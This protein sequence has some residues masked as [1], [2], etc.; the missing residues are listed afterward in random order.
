MNSYIAQGVTSMRQEAVKLTA[1]GQYK[2]IVWEQVDDVVIEVYADE[3]NIEY[4]AK[5]A[6]EIFYTTSSIAFIAAL[7]CALQ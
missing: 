6:D 7:H 5:V 3:S 4:V 2:A 1:L